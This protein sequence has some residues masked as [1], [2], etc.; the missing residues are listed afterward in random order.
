METYRRFWTERLD[1]MEAYL[2]TL[3]SLAPASKEEQ[4][5]E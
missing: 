4:S 1:K 5:D 2:A 3:A